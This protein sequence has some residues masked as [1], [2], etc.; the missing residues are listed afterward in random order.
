MAFG[1]RFPQSQR[2]EILNPLAK[3]R[4]STLLADLLICSRFRAMSDLY[5]RIGCPVRLVGAADDPICPPASAL[6]LA[7]LLPSAELNIL[8]DCGHLLLYEKTTLISHMLCDFLE[9]VNS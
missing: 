7:Y 9:K 8:S 6:Q 2:R 5:H 1:K 3:M 4:T